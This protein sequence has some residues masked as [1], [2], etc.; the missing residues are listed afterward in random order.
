MRE[1]S[2]QQVQLTA[3]HIYES[4]SE[5]DRSQVSSTCWQNGLFTDTGDIDCNGHPELLGGAYQRY[6]NV[7]F[8][9]EVLAALIV[10]PVC[11]DDNLS[12]HEITRLAC[13]Y[14][15]EEWVVRFRVLIEPLLD[16]QTNIGID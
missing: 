9:C 5:S 14:K 3:Q 1:L 7:E 6:C 8:A 4:M 16:N 12:A 11:P 15:I 2:L 13:D 10:L